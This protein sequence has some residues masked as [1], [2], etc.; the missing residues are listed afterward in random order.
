MTVGDWDH[1]G[2]PDIV[3]N[4]I[5]GRINWCRNVGTRSKP[6]LGAPR[7]VKVAGETS[8]PEWN[9]WNP[10]PGELVTQW[11][12][13]PVIVDWN[14]DGLNDL[15]MLDHEGYLCLFERRGEDDGFAVSAGERM[16]V[17]ES[18]APIRLN[19]RRA[20]GSG[21]RKLAVVDWDGDGRL[22]LLGNSENADW[23]RNLGEHNGKVVLLNTGMMDPRKVSGHTSSPTTI[24]LNR[25]KIPE[26]LVGAE[27]G[28]LY[29][30]DAPRIK[31]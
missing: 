19:E 10:L 21:R 17:D 25:D 29:Y 6:V 30:R 28:R 22:D 27:D 8:K 11:R 23:Y 24:D 14:K 31:K 20:G 26:L 15:I 7:P 5:W 13:T 12:T 16:F 2:L 18:G 1:D 9:W 4:S 3:F